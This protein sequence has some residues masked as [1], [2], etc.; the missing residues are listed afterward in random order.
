MIIQ[1][2][3][4]YYETIYSAERPYNIPALIDL[5]GEGDNETAAN[6]QAWFDAHHDELTI[7]WQDTNSERLLG[8]LIQNLVHN[9][10]PY[11]ESAIA[12]DLRGF[13]RFS[14]AHCGTYSHAQLTLAHAL[15]LPARLLEF[16]D[17]AHGWIEM[18]I[19][20]RWEV[21]DATANVWFDRSMAEMLEGK[22][23][24]YRAFYTPLSDAN[25]PEAR[26]HIHT[27]G[28]YYNAALFRARLICIGLCYHPT[29]AIRP[30]HGD[31]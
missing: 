4:L 25:R 10:V 2:P 16:D 6:V 17:G 21:F 27:S 23:R 13:T 15:N 5:L 29:G 30:Y 8:W 28:G 24:I 14:A 11:G 12:P 3:L 26:A 19:G 9:A 22:A 18:E 20:G 7:V 31:E 1:P